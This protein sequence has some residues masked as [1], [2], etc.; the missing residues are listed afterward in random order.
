MNRIP[1]VWAIALLALASTPA[2][3]QAQIAHFPPCVTQDDCEHGYTCHPTPFTV[4]GDN[5][6]MLSLCDTEAD[7][8]PDM[9]C[10]PPAEPRCEPPRQCT[11]DA[12][13]G[14]CMPSWAAP[15]TDDVDCGPYMHCVEREQ[16]GCWWWEDS[17]DMPC[18]CR[19]EGVFRCETIPYDCDPIDDASC[20][21]DWICGEFQPRHYECTQPPDPGSSGSCDLIEEPRTRSCLAPQ[22]AF[23]ESFQSFSIPDDAGTGPS[24]SGPGG[25]GGMSAGSGGQ[26]GSGGQP[27]IPVGGVTGGTSTAG[28]GV[29]GTS[30][31]SSGGQPA[32]PDTGNATGASGS[33]AAGS[34]SAGGGSNLD[35][36]VPTTAMGPSGQGS[37]G[38]SITATGTGHPGARWM[39]ALIGFAVMLGRPRSRGAS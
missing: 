31:T 3:T 36:A 11:D 39:L 23:I 16:C 18:G 7:C 27:G 28:T 35:A 24:L 38:C 12:E 32:T 6:C 10:V 25:V 37:S 26:G 22:Y 5:W 29:A 21:P 2:L 17:P 4:L 13:R 14:Q 30:T 33:G 9:L 20:A 19:G 8:P 1:H 34:A 15:C